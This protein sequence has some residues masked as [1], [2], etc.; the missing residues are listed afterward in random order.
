MNR[1]DKQPSM[2]PEG[3]QGEGNKE[4]DR[5]YREKTKEFVDSGRVEEAAR[6]AKPQS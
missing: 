6:R 4:A 2:Q 3:N 5:H 1:S